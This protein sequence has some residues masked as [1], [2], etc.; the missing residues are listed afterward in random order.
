MAANGTPDPWAQSRPPAR[1]TPWRVPIILLLLAIALGAFFAS[2]TAAAMGPGE[3]GWI[4]NLSIILALMLAFVRL[5]QR[6]STTVLHAGI[7]TGLV[8]AVVIGHSHYR[9]IVALYDRIAADL[10]PSS[11]RT[12]D[13]HAIA[14]SIANDG[15][16]WI[17]A[18]ADGKSV[19]FMLDTGASDIVLTKADA[20]RLGFDLADLAFNQVFNTANGKTRAAPISLD[21]LRIGPIV[22]TRVHAY[23]NEGELHQSLLG[24]AFLARM[25]SLE[26][27]DDVLTI[28]R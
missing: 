8:L 9:E 28:R 10:V 14:F 7:W 5:R 15:H 25:A 22:L 11:G 1:R 21:E 24:M 23:V 4:V 13:A 26:I 17:D 16:Y 6:L 18:R 12:I 20:K 27:K 19:R 3:Q 2:D